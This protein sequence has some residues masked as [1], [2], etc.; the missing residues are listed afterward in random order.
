MNNNPT[1]DVLPPRPDPNTGEPFPPHGRA[2]HGDDQ[3]P[4]DNLYRETRLS[5]RPAPPSGKSPVL[6]WHKENRRGKTAIFVGSIAFLVLALIL[7][8]AVAGT[9]NPLAWISLWQPWIAILGSAVLMTRPFT[10]VKTSAGA[11]W[12]QCQ[13][14]RFGVTIRRKHLNLYQLRKIS[15]TTGPAALYLELADED[16]SI[17]LARTYWQ[18][19]RRIWDLVY[20]GILHSVAAGAEVD[21]NAR[22]FL[23]LDRVP[24]LQHSESYRQI[25]VTHLSDDHVR[26]LMKD[27]VVRTMCDSIHF[28]GNAA[29]FRELFP[30]FDEGMLA[31]PANPEW[32]ATD[33]EEEVDNSDTRHNQ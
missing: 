20:N 23:E 4:E 6:T 27:P 3:P 14:V 29:E 5:Y 28:E 17:D 13:I 30:E 7:V 11:A 8:R 25:D 2:W 1:G 32:F 26:E 31:K 24:E 18:F 9:G 12:F 22:G 10:Y 16:D 19:D 21:R 15:A 33:T